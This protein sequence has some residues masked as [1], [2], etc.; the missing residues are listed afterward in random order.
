[1]FQEPSYIIGDF[2]G[3]HARLAFARNGEIQ[4]E[5]V[6]IYQESP[7]PVDLIRSFLQEYAGRFTAEYAIF[8]FAGPVIDGK[9]RMTNL[10]FYST[11]EEL[12]QT[13]GFKSVH[14]LNDFS[15]QVAAVPFLEEKDV[16]WIGG[17][18]PSALA[19]PALVLGPGTGF[20]VGYSIDGKVMPSEGGGS[21]FAPFDE[22]DIDFWRFLKKAFPGQVIAE[23]VLS[24][25]GLSR[26]YQFISRKE[27]IVS[28]ETICALA[29]QGDPAAKEAFARFFL[30]LARFSGDMAL[31][32]HAGSVYLAGGILQKEEVRS[33]M[34]ID[35]FRKAFSEKYARDYMLN[36]MPIGIIIRPHA[37][38]LG[39]SKL[40]L[41]LTE[42][43]S[44]S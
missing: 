43:E 8:A 26:L 12:K 7:S 25:R 29:H 20:G 14:L 34:D 37:A 1:M 18:K 19:S 38:L 24:G 6:F 2:G 36:K 9:I 3:T 40:T 42:R 16:V 35:A 10:N 13:L 30:Y 5:R 28:P 31:V 21:S 32:T 33:L 27:E 41:N 22:F 11:A 17:I 39:L 44:L 23:F 4:A 15:A